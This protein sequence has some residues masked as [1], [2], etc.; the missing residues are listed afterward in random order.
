MIELNQTRLDKFDNM[1]EHHEIVHRGH[2][3]EKRVIN[4]RMLVTNEKGFRRRHEEKID[5]MTE[6]G[7][8]NQIDV[9]MLSKTNGKCTT[10]TTDAMS[11]KIKVLG[12]E[13]T[14][15]HANSKAHKTI[16]SDWFQGGLM[17]VITGK[18]SSLI[19]HQQEK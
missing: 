10:R 13:T 7:K 4:T 17:N 15:Y 19:Q 18:M 8:N 1:N 11:S 9:V 6:F 12:R 3:Y 16:D 14:C 2:L 5:Q